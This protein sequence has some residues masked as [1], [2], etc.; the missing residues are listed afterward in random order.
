MATFQNKTASKFP[1]NDKINFQHQ[2][3]VV[4]YGECPNPNCKDDYIGGTDRRVMERVIN[5]SKQVQS[6]MC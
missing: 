4:Y 1:V 2:N 5:L 6:P 3:N